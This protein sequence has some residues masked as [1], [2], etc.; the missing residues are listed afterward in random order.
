MVRDADAVPLKNPASPPRNKPPKEKK[1]YVA[2]SLHFEGA[3]LS[4]ISGMGSVVW[5]VEGHVEHRELLRPC[6]TIREPDFHRLLHGPESIE[7]C[8]I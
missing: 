6:S 8:S 4:V 5:S 2:A 3:N 7:I 1:K